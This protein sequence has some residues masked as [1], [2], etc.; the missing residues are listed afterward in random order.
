MLILDQAESF[1]SDYAASEHFMFLKAPAKEDAEGLLLA[2]FRQAADRGLATLSD[3]KAKDVEDILFTAMPR[4]DI[5]TTRKR[6]LPDLL[7]G[8]FTFLKDSGRFPPAS[9][10][11]MC[12]ESVRKRFVDSIRE[13]GTVKGTTFKKQ[14]TDVGRNDPCPCGSGQKF[15]KCCMPLLA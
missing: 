13:D 15:K 10:W 1:I 11:Q 14:Y 7:D 2:F 4:L 12:I 5:P 3:L 9:A 8:F 6:A